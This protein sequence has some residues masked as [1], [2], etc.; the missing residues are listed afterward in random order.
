MEVTHVKEFL[1]LAEICNYGR[2]AEA[3]YIS[4]STLFNHIRS[5][6]ADIGA[7]LFDK[8][9]R[10]IVLSEYGQLFLPY[11]NTI[12]D[13]SE[14]FAN[15]LQDSRAKK[16]SVLRIAIQYPITELI[17]AFRKQHSHYGI[18]FLDSQAPTEML[19]E[20]SCELAFIRNATPETHPEYHVMP[21]LSD[22]IV[23][24]VYSGHPLAGRKSVTLSELRGEDFVMIA[25]RKK[26]DCY[27][28]NL[29]K[30]AGFVPKV[31]MTA[32]TGS[33]AV[34]MVNAGFGISLFLRGTMTPD[35]FEHLILL[36][37]EPEILCSVS[38]CW[39]K[40]KPLSQGARAFVQ[41]LSEYIHK[42]E[43]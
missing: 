10:K 26:R 35:N 15:I 37:L 18:L 32:A 28:M 34:K 43:G 23:A 19:T 7:P 21:Y 13:A 9:G 27:C 40:D 12:V 16:D 14:E 4:Q 22:A 39:R 5:L 2:A 11:A 24:A 17:Q 6:E 25:Q 41:F 33:E 36:D 8:Q 1:A 31:A 3:M 42:A 30:R 29:C 20:G 38:L